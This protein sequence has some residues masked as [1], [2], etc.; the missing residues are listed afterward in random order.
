[1]ALLNEIKVF[2][3]HP[4]NMRVLLLANFIFAL[5][6]P[7][8]DLFVV[9]YVMR[10]SQDM[11]LVMSYSVAL[12][13]GMPFTFLLNGLLLRLF[14][15]KHLFCFGII[16]SPVA[17][18]TIMALPKLEIG[19]LILTGLMMGVSFGIYWANRDI[20]TLA[21]TDDQNRNYYYSMGTVFATLCGLVVPI[22][23]GWFISCSSMYGWFGGGTGNAYHILNAIALLLSCLSARVI[24]RGTFRNP[25]PTRFI[26]F[27]YHPMWY[28][29][30]WMSALR[31]LSQGFTTATPA[32]L[33]MMLMGGKEGVLGT[34]QTGGTAV[35]VIG[36]YLIGRMA[37]TEH[38]LGLMLAGLGLY[39]LATISNAL[40]FNVAG[41]IAYMFLQMLGGPLI[42]NTVLQVQMRAINF[43]EKKENRNFLAYLFSCEFGLWAGRL[44][45]GLLFIAVAAF[46]EVAALRYVLVAIALLQTGAFFFGKKILAEC[47]NP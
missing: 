47:D 43:L 4:R 16:L 34:L 6:S 18:A 37:R 5:V 39:L 30:L 22:S 28:R 24:C 15:I 17:M 38:R 3:S 21:C 14:G 36:M 35:T 26:Y 11:R 40:L 13:T 2:L 10:T 9:A 42:E 45:G 23:A 46:S 7:I 1:M 19:G 41:V 33:V 25:E 32:M 44:S 12:F 8:V 20:L 27:R 31:G 29:V